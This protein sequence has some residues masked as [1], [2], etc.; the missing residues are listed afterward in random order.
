MVMNS[1][2]WGFEQVTAEMACLCLT[3]SESSPSKT[4]NGGDQDS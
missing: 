1:V 2:G 4:M 3:I